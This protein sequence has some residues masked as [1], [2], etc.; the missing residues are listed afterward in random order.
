MMRQSPKPYAKGKV[1]R[2]PPRPR[3]GKY[4]QGRGHLSTAASV[5]HQKTSKPV[6][7]LWGLSP[8]NHPFVLL[9]GQ[10]VSIRYGSV[11]EPLRGFYLSGIR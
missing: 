10:P 9:A 5:E 3:S 6:G 2:T 11:W 8:T 7:H 1:R 4:C